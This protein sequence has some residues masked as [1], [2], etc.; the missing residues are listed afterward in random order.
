MLNIALPVRLVLFLVRRRNFSCLCRSGRPFSPG[1]FD[2]LKNGKISVHVLHRMGH[3]SFGVL[4]DRNNPRSI[5]SPSLYP[6]I[7]LREFHSR[8]ASDQ[9]MLVYSYSFSSSPVRSPGRR[10][11]TI[12]EGCLERLSSVRSSYLLFFVVSA[13]HCLAPAALTDCGRPLFAWPPSRWDSHILHIYFPLAC[14][15][16]LTCLNH[17][18]PLVINPSGS[19]VARLSLFS[20]MPSG[21]SG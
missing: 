2:S 3:H 9:K 17:L 8:S 19:S 14:H 10:D 6:T 1:V 5:T 15:T 16:L 18:R 13:C 4:R 7:N 21:P 20:V 11:A 12:S